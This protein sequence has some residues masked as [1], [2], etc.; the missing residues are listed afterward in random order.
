MTTGWDKFQELIKEQ[1]RKIYSDV[2]IEHAMDPRNIGRMEDADCFVSVLGTCGDNIELWLK[3]DKNVITDAS[4]TTNGCSATIACGSLM[5]ELAKLKTLGEALTI[6][7]KKLIEELG[8]LP[9]DH[10]HCA[11]LASLTLKKAIVEY[12]NSTHNHGKKTNKER[13]VSKK[14]F[15]VNELEAE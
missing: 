14:P 1:M 11:G 3:V 4:F 9:Q 2:Y 15:R 6:T 12:M 13:A 5:T 10:V 7:A 8:G